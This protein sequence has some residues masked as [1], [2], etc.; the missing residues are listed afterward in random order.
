M[1]NNKGNFK[2]NFVKKKDAKEHP[3]NEGNCLES[4]QGLS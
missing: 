2:Q 4:N 3:N 1:K